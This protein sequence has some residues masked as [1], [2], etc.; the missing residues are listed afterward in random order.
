MLSELSAPTS[1]EN[2]YSAE[3]DCDHADDWRNESFILGGDGERSDLN[4]LSVFCVADSAHGE[5]HRAC[6]N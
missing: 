1:R 6:E 5:N 4:G 2:Q 3:Y